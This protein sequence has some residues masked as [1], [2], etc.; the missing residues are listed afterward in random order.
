MNC[1]NHP[2]IPATAF[3]RNCGKPLCDACKRAA[4]GTV[5]CEE[6]VPAQP[7]ASAPPAAAPV[8]SPPPVAEPGVS[9]GLAFALGLVIP[10]VGAI[11]NGQYAKGLVHAVIFGLLVS[12]ISSGSAHGL[13]PLFGF[14]IAAW[15]FYMGLE[16]YHTA[17]KRRAGEPV[18][19]FSSL[20]NLHTKGS[21][22][23]AGAVVLI[24]LGVLLL[25]NTTD[26]IPFERVLRYW[27][28]LLILLGVY[29]LYVRLAGLGERSGG[30]ASGNAPKEVQ[31][32]ER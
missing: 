6:H 20:I 26:I 19:E 21:R 3:C 24:G 15:V 10:G 17:Q 14:L 11:Y 5:Y 4:H 2:E 7:A 25:L 1:L 22:F 16:A 9:P 27:P 18:D 13:E 30:A 28:V 8:Y 29:L 12:I 23:P 32:D 31:H